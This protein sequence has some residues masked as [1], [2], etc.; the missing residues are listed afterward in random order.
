M[1]E[2]SAGHSCRRSF[3]PTRLAAEAG[4]RTQRSRWVG[5]PQGV[6]HNDEFVSLTNM[7]QSGHNQSLAVAPKISGERPFA[8]AP[9]HEHRSSGGSE[10][11]VAAPER[12]NSAPAAR[13]RRGRRP[14]CAPSRPRKSH[15]HAPIVPSSG[16]Q[17]PA[18]SRGARRLAASESR[19]HTFTATKDGSSSPVAAWKATRPAAAESQ[20]PSM[21]MQ[22]KR[23][24][25]HS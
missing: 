19:T 8:R 24:C 21:T 3:A 10:C 17:R 22:W 1:P 9:T 23:K 16:R 13:A 7:S 18:A 6:W 5:A 11:A 20:T 14:R 2:K 15:R 4:E 12:R 25:L